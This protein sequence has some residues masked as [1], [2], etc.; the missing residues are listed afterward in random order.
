MNRLTCLLLAL[1][2]IACAPGPGTSDGGPT[3]RVPSDQLIAT[4]SE[5]EAVELSEHLDAEG[6][7]LFEYGA[8]W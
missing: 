7:T 3:G 5:G 4:I 8:E 6:W 2:L 1:G